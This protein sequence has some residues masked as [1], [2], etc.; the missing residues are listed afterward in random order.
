MANSQIHKNEK[1]IKKI[2]KSFHS[3]LS[4]KLRF[5]LVVILRNVISLKNVF[6]KKK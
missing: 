1:K 2:K 4:H 6:D 5:H 3:K